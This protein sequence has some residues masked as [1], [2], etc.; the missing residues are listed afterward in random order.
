[1]H[2]A[3]KPAEDVPVLHDASRLW[4]TPG[5]R[6]ILECGQSSG[7]LF[8][9]FTG[10]GQRGVM[11]ANESCRHSKTALRFGLMCFGICET[12]AILACISNLLTLADCFLRPAFPILQLI[13]GVCSLA[14]LWSSGFLARVR[15]PPIGSPRQRLSL[16]SVGVVNQGRPTNITTRTRLRNTSSPGCCRAC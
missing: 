6:Q 7:P 1:L 10:C 15:A 14:L 13:L 12:K 16:N 3:E 11:R 5:L 8:N 2:G 4:I 9:S